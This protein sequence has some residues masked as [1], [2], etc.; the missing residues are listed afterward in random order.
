MTGDISVVD[1]TRLQ[2]GLEPRPSAYGSAS[3]RTASSPVLLDS[4]LRGEHHQSLMVQTTSDSAHH[5]EDA[6]TQVQREGTVSAPVKAPPA[7]RARLR[8]KIKG[9]RRGK[10]P[11]PPRRRPRQPLTVSARDERKEEAATRIAMR[12]MPPTATPGFQLTEASAHSIARLRAVCRR[13]FPIRFGINCELDREHPVLPLRPCLRDTVGTVHQRATSVE[14][15]GIREVNGGDA[16]RV[17][18]YGTA[19]R[20]LLALEPAVHVELGNVVDRHPERRQVRRQAPQP[21]HPPERAAVCVGPTELRPGPL[22]R[23]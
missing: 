8:T 7:R 23:S 4:G 21:I 17:A 15:D 3:T 14:D 13:L 1:T 10:G 19:G 6:T 20:R 12:A 5:N 18:G 2:L 22:I 16:L 11:S 9:C